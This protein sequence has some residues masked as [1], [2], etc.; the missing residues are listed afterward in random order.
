MTESYGTAT[1]F[2]PIPAFSMGAWTDD[3][4]DMDA[5]GESYGTNNN[6]YHHR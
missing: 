5:D 3:A 1:N 2:D 4:T 6:Y